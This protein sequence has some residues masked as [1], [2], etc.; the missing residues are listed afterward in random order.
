MKKAVLKKHKDLCYQIKYK[1]NSKE[2]K[3]PISSTHAFF[4]LLQIQILVL[5]DNM[6]DIRTPVTNTIL[7]QGKLNRKID[8]E[9]VFEF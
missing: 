4:M 7:L 1:S 8:C 2:L 9:G 6:L 5:I 3:F